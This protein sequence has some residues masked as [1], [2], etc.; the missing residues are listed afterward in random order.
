MLSL[1]RKAA[2][3][4]SDG[5]RAKSIASRIEGSVYT[6]Q[7][8]T[9]CRIPCNLS[10][11]N[12]QA[13]ART[14]HIATEK[15][16]TLQVELANWYWARSTVG[17]ETNGGG[18]ITYTASIEYPAGVFKQVL[19]SGSASAVVASGASVLS[20]SVGVDIPKGARFWVRTFAVAVTAIV[21]TD[22]NTGFPQRDL[23]NGEAYEYAVS[24]LTDKTMGGTVNDVGAASAPIFS[25]TAIV[26]PTKRP[27]VLILGDSRDWG[28]TDIPEDD[29]DLGDLAR[30]IGKKFGYINAGCAGDTLSA[31][32]AGHTKRAALQQYVSHVVF[33]DPINALRSGGSGQ[34]KTAATV[35]GELQTILGYFPT[36]QCI[37]TTPGGPNSTSTDNWATLA[38]QTVNANQAQIAAYCAAIRAGVANSIGY[39]DLMYAVESSRDSGK[40]WVNGTAQATTTDGLHSTQLGYKRIRDLGVVDLSLISRAG[41]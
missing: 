23:S 13:N 14:A 39:W 18:N 24:G 15:L 3:D 31:F 35:L 1:Q 25:P 17:P 5:L 6:G 10:A 8:A 21:F 7:V 27:S 16:S 11:T 26:A 30:S 12:K 9:R 38:N 36:K 19:F 20:D 33:G 2:Y 41:L 37:T 40:W 4:E 29:G 34:N 32:I 28:F 22:S